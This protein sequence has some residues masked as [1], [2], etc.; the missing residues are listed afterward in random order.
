MPT[1]L[2]VKLLRVLQEREVRPVGDTRTIPIDVRVLSATHCDMD[3]RVA[4]GHFREDLFYRLNVV[5]LRLP[6]LEQRREDIALLVNHRLEQ[7]GA[8]EI[9]RASWRERGGKYV[10]I[11]V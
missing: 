7:P 6:S 4:D 9:G 10:K 1:A 5:R 11:S 8:G 3:S 2:Q